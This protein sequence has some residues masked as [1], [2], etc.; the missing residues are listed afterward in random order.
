MTTTTGSSY[1]VSSGQSATES[2]TTVTISSGGAAVSSFTFSSGDTISVA[3]GG[4]ASGLTLTA[5]ETLYE[6]K[7]NLA[8]NIT[9]ITISSGG[10]FTQAYS[11]V[12]DKVSG[13]VVSSGGTFSATAGGGDS[14]VSVLSGGTMAVISSSISNPI[15]VF[16]GAEI[17]LNQLS[18]ST[19]SVA[20]SFGSSSNGYYEAITGYIPGGISQ[21]VQFAGAGT[22]SF[23]TTSGGTGDYLN[24]TGVTCFGAGTAILTEQGEVA[25]ESIKLGDKVTVR[26]DGREVQEPVIW[27]GYSSVDLRRHAHPE[28][29]APIL[30]AAGALAEGLPVRDLVVSPEHCMIVDGHCVPAKLLV[31]G[32]TISREFPQTPFMYYHIELERH[33]ILIAD[34]AEAESYLDTGNRASF[35]NAGEPRLLHPTFQV[36]ADAARWKTEACAPL[37]TAPEDVAPIWRKLAD[38][39]IA[40]GFE[41]PTVEAVEDP[42]LHLI[43]DGRRIEAVSDREARF[44]FPVPAGAKSVVL[45]SRASI[46]AD[47][48]TPLVRDTRRI[49]VRVLWAA[50]RAGDTETIFPGDHPALRQGW[51]QVD[52]HGSAP[53]RWTNGAA[54]IPWE[55]IDGAATLTVHC[56]PSGWYPV[57][58]GAVLAA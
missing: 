30:I 50:I 26:R 3:S 57:E 38:R 54:T 47:Q 42:D 27:V 39:A 49:G 32:T 43:V 13:V 14:G 52:T 37:A 4:I 45:A 16:G 1:T 11:N 46:L 40:L 18:G 28:L 29:A 17:R 9:N 58:Q 35:D 53:W 15:T 19:F 36:N 31:N 21:S 23:T 8:T 33:G 7:T 24:I 12:F 48:M 51:H 41:L 55:N 25:V 56:Y 20:S 5:G 6:A 34:G 2:G 10:T 22:V 44:V